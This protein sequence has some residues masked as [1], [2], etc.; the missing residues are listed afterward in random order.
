M[1]YT[2]N[3]SFYTYILQKERKNE[4]R[5]RAGLRVNVRIAPRASG[6]RLPRTSLRRCVS[7]KINRDLYRGSNS[8]G[9]QGSH[10]LNG[11]HHRECEWLAL[12][13]RHE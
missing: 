6:K 1:K 3:Y 9:R 5:L 13:G 11:S 7:I 12:I 10:S 8:E 2:I 4:H